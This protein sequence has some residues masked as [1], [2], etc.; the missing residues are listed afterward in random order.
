MFCCHHFNVL[1]KVCVLYSGF[2]DNLL[3]QTKNNN[4]E[5][6]YFNMY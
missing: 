5:N 4:N 6:A 3:K 1:I 2:Y